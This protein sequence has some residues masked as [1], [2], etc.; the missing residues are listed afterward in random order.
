MLSFFHLLPSIS[1]I[2]CFSQPKLSFIPYV[3]C[4]LP[5]LNKRLALTLNSWLNT[6]GQTSQV[7]ACMMGCFSAVFISLTSLSALISLMQ[8]ELSRSRNLGRCEGSFTSCTPF[9]KETCT[10]SSS[11]LSSPHR[12]GDGGAQ[13]S[14]FPERHCPLA[15]CFRSPGRMKSKLTTFQTSAK[16]PSGKL[17]AHFSNRFYIPIVINS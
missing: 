17:G 8:S 6:R 2:R 13:A 1:Y 5:K 11:G 16:D 12:P 7:P 9:S 10:S 4:N 3:K 15:W 14:A